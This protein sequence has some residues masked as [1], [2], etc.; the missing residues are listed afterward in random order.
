MK[1][2]FLVTTLLFL[3]LPL[4]AG[5]TLVD[6]DHSAD[7]SRYKTFAIEAGTPV[8]ELTQKQIEAD[9]RVQLEKEGLTEAR[10]G[11]KPD[12]V[13]STHGTTEKQVKQ[14][15]ANINVGVSKRTSRGNRVGLSTGNRGRAQQVETGSL[16]IDLVDKA[17]GELVWQATATDVLKKDPDKTQALILKSIEK[18]FAQYPPG[19]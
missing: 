12:L 6:W 15:G 13:V 17:S 10:K 4:H 3:A 9:L 19:Q 11:E 8:S 18:V 2:T 5:K 7:F 16:V 14:K 1:K